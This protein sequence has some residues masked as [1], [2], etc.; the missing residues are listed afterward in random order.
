MDIDQLYTYLN[1]DMQITR[2]K[3]LF[4]EY[5]ETCIEKYN[6]DP[7]HGPAIAYDI[8]GLL[9]TKFATELPDDDPYVEIMNIAG[10]L[11]LPESHR[12]QHDNWQY[13]IQIAQRLN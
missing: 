9:S 5:V 3:G 1:E 12:L 7:E 4:R 11:E 10:R 8:A 6:T 13:F 2:K